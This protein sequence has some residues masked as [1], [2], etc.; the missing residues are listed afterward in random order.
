MLIGHFSDLHGNLKN[1]LAFE[2]KPDVWLNTGDLF[3]DCPE[4]PYIGTTPRG[5]TGLYQKQ[6]FH[7]NKDAFLRKLDGVPLIT[8]MGN[9]DAVDLHKYLEHLHPT[10][11]LT[12]QG[13]DLLGV[14]WAGFGETP[15]ELD[16]VGLS[17]LATQ[18]LSSNPQIV[19]THAPPSHVLCG[20]NPSWGLRGLNQL[21]EAGGH[22]VRMHFFGHVHEMGGIGDRKWGVQFVNG[23]CRVRG[24]HFEP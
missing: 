16:Q 12:P 1:L 7:K 22:T 18:T 14:R 8:C 15:L 17:E 21:L 10:Y 5:K 11:R 2:G 3:P 24:W 23:A 9:H 20:S 19:A 6:W 4:D 13:F